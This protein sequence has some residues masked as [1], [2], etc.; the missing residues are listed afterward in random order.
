MKVYIVKAP[1]GEYESYQE[2][3]VKVFANKKQARDYVNGEN[4]KL[5]L[6]QAKKCQNCDFRCVLG[7]Q[8][9][10]PKPSCWVGEY[11]FCEPYFEKYR[12]VQKLFMEEYEV[13]E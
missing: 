11:Y 4:A 1:Q 12:D 2:P 10:K 7:E 6:Q 13:E 3:I 8:E 9:H 5:P